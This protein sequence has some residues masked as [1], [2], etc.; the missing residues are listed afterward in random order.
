MKASRSSRKREAVGESAK[1]MIGPY[2]ARPRGGP[3]RS[4]LA[5]HRV[6][7]V[8]DAVAVEAVEREVALAHRGVLR[9]AVDVVLHTTGRARSLCS[10]VVDDLR[11][12]LRAESEAALPLRVAVGG[13]D[14]R[15]HTGRVR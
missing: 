7:G 12:L 3:R 11:R 13:D 15:G 9:A 10:G 1:S 8:D 2:V 5:E 6:Q 14:E 4:V